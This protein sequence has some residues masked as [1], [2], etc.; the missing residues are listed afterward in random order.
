MSV[1]SKFTARPFY[2]RRIPVFILDTAIFGLLYI[3]KTVK[4]AKSYK[5]NARPV[6]NFVISDSVKWRRSFDS[7]Y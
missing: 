6:K 2:F 5:K 1:S 3:Y 7:D 4:S